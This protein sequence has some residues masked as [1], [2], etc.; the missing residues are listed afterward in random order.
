MFKVAK[1]NFVFSTFFRFYFVIFSYLFC[2]I[3]NLQGYIA[4][5]SRHSPSVKNP[6]FALAISDKSVTIKETQISIYTYA[7]GGIF[8]TIYRRFVCLMTGLFLL[9]L[10]ASCACADTGFSLFFDGDIQPGQQGNAPVY[11]LEE[12]TAKEKTVSVNGQT[13]ITV[14]GTTNPKTEGANAK[15]TV[16][17]RGA[18][19]YVLAPSD[20]T[21][22]VHGVNGTNSSD[23]SGKT[24]WVVPEGGKAFSLSTP[25]EIHVEYEA[26]A[27]EK[28]WFYAA[29]SKFCYAGVTFIPAQAAAESADFLFRFIDHPLSGEYGPVLLLED[30]EIKEE[31]VTVAGESLPVVQGKNNPKA[32]GS[33]AKGTIPHTGAAVCVT[34]PADGTLTCHGIN[35][36]NSSD[37][38]GKTFWVV[39]EGGKAFSLSTPGEIHVEYEAAAGEKVWF[40]AAGS[41][42]R[43]AAISFAGKGGTD[44]SGPIADTRPWQFIRFGTSTSDAANRIGD[45]PSLEKGVTLFS[46]TSDADGNIVKK[47]GKFVS[48]A[49]ADGISFYYTT[50]NPRTENFCLTADVHVDYLNPTPDGQ[51]GFALMVRDTISGSGSYYSNL[52]SVASSKLRVNGKDTKGVLGSRHYTGIV[53]SENTDLNNVNDIRIAFT[54]DEND[55]V[56]QGKTYRIRLEKTSCAYI[57]SQFEILPDGTTGPLISSYT[58]YI[59]AADAGATSVS[60][61]DELNDPL[62][63]QEKENAYLGLTCARGI[64][65]TFTN[66]TFTTSPW[67][68]EEWHVQPTTYLDGRCTVKSA[69]TCAEDTYTLAFSTN[70]DGTA[71]IRLNGQ[72]V[73]ASVPVTAGVQVERSYPLHG[74]ALFTIDFT[75]SPSFVFSAFEKLSSYD[76]MT[77]THTV[78]KR[79]IGA[80]NGVIYVS[81]QGHAQNGGT[82]YEDALDI[83]TALDY[84]S[85]GQTIL[86]KP[87]TY[88]LPQQ[89]LTISRG[90]N[91]TQDAP[92]RLQGDGGYATLD[93]QGTG[94]GFTAWGDWWQMEK[95]NICRTAPLQKGMQLSGHHNILKN[96]NFYNNGTTGLQLSGTSAETIEMWPSHNTV[97]SCTAMNN[98][99]P[100]YEDADGFAAKLT[101]GPGNVFDQCMAAYNADDGWDLFAKAATGPI[102]AVTIQNSVAFR[103]GYLMV[104]PGSKKDNILFAEILCNENG[105][106]SF[107][108]ENL[109]A[110]EAGNGNGFKMGGTNIPGRHVLINSIAYEN[111]AKGIDANSCPDIRVYHSTSFNNGAHNVAFY[112]GNASASTGYEAKGVLSFRTG[113]GSGE[114]IKLQGQQSKAVYGE[115]NFYWNGEKNVSENTKSSP[116]CVNESW[117]RSLDTSALPERTADGRIDMHGLLLLTDEARVYETGA[118]GAAWGQDEPARASVWVVG[119]STVSAFDDQYFIPREGWGEQIDRYF[120]ADVYNL[121][122]SGASSKDFTEMEEYDMLLNGSEQVPALGSTGNDMF[123]LIGFGHNDEKTEEARFTSPVGDYRTE[124]TF[125]NSLYVHY[126]KPALDRGVTPILVTPIVRLTEENTPASYRSEAGHITQ[127]TVIGGVTYPGGDYAA[128]I[129]QM[130]SDLSIPCIDLTPATLEMNVALGENAKYLHAFNGA[131]YDADGVTKVPT[132]LDKTHTNSYG[133]KMHAWLIARHAD[134]TGLDAYVKQGVPAPSYEADFAD[135]INPDYQIIQYTAPLSPSANWPAFTDQDGNVWHGTVFGDVGGD[136]KVLSGSFASE[137]TDAGVT[138][139]VRDNLGKISSTTDGFLFYYI[140]LPAGTPFT[141]TATATVNQL[142]ANNQVSFGLMARDELYI[143]QNIRDTMG[144]YVASGSRNQ[145]AVNCFGRKSGLLLDGPAAQHV[146]GPGDTLTLSITGTRDGFTLQYGENEPVSAGFDYALTTIDEATVYVGFYVVRNASVTFSDIHLILE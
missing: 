39:P 24:F 38:S 27:G 136:S 42:F 4:S 112:T 65:A 97:I 117:F 29:G 135:T 32:D 126:V 121:A 45:G 37:G 83:Q 132:A 49:P 102:G 142:F 21:I 17:D 20:G 131:R 51:E 114:N 54:Q 84:A 81:A 44:M 53:S 7:S 75:P 67:K 106:L 96:M 123:L 43:Y 64:N 87:E 61:Y 14:Q 8:M 89:S 41:K 13:H 71:L 19:L 110:V 15:G 134:G 9:F 125:A 111:K 46:C 115:N 116:A 137:V 68:A 95:I 130:C 138:L 127:T 85:A 16:P 122:R 60:S 59:P 144:D 35:G 47:G 3:C 80:E 129:R 77:V 105:H 141:L 78:T 6:S 18:A 73:D 30:M 58:Y 108:G 90:R 140:P 79:H 12:M 101:C 69:A 82:S 52:F 1:N 128:S 91:G 92:I 118:R 55:L 76:T 31:T 93:F 10:C 25:G 146:Y 145:G 74:D 139:S 2:I 133:A 119:D 94:G 124:G 104:Q 100:G 62:C 36:T 50:I 103:N 34:A 72:T 11:V 66:I 113:N 22:T 33:N 143:D 98:G 120:H 107:T 57:T 70:A 28:V 40:Y 23:G 63:V 56:Q 88:L 5:F 86:L 26:A 109:T 48:D 99:D